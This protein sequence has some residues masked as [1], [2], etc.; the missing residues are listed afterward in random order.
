MQLNLEIESKIYWLVFFRFKFLTQ[1]ASPCVL[2]KTLAESIACKAYKNAKKKVIKS[3]DVKALLNKERE[4]RYTH[5]IPNM[6]FLK[7]KL[8]TYFSKVL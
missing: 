2:L 4:L 5:H 3:R 6:N 1:S 7:K 8:L